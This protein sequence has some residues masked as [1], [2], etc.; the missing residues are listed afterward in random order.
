MPQ[1]RRFPFPILAP[2]E[3]VGLS[4]EAYAKTII[5]PAPEELCCPALEK[6]G[7][8]RH[9]N[10]TGNSVF[11]LVRDYVA[12]APLPE[13]ELL[14]DHLTLKHLPPNHPQAFH[15]LILLPEE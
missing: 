13:K 15:A 8:P 9:H 5:R 6:W 11:G 4:H 2:I 12:G 3:G 1:D 10:V 7:L 14:G